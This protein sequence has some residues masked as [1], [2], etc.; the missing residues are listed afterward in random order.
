MKYARA[1]DPRPPV[2]SSRRSAAGRP[3]MS[4]LR[5]ASAPPRELQSGLSLQHDRGAT[6]TPEVGSNV[7]AI[8][9]IDDEERETSPSGR[10]RSVAAAGRDQ[11]S[12]HA[13]LETIGITAARATAR[14][15]ARAL[16]HGTRTAQAVHVPVGS[17]ISRR[18]A[19]SSSRP[20]SEAI[21]VRARGGTNVERM[22]APV[23]ASAT[24]LVS[25]VLASRTCNKVV[26]A[27]EPRNEEHDEGTRREEHGDRP[28]TVMPAI[29]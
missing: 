1:P 13:P 24:R 19:S 26:K 5:P 23:K 27:P 7:V 20:A 14:R 12:G 18:A 2:R 25:P 9:V 6:I 22:L 3:F 21:S 11:I 15:E 10:R 16:G 29:A 4:R 8:R 17:L 28:A